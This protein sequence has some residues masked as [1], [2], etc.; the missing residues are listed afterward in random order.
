MIE[1]VLG[2]LAACA[3][4]FFSNPL[5]VV[6]TRL[7]LQGELRARN[8]Y[9]VRYR[10]VF[11]AFYAVAAADGILA[12]QKGLVP[13]LWYQL[14]MNGARLGTYQSFI[15][16]GFTKSSNG[17]ISVP[18]S[19]LCGATA[20]C[21]GAFIGSPFYLVKT[22]LQSQAAEQ[23]AVGHQH[24]HVGAT[25]A[26]VNIYKE[27]GIPGLWRGVTGAIPRV[28]V[29]SSTQLATFSKSKDFIENLDIFAKDSWLNA[30]LASMASAC[31]VITFMTPFDVVSTR[32]YN[33]GVDSG[34][35][36]LYYD[37]F[38][39]CFSKVLRTEGPTGFY[40]GW[41]A[42]LFRLGPHT[43]LS[44]VFWSKLRGVYLEWEASDRM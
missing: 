16:L 39:D 33:Q 7:Q 18:R 27:H 32:L 9:T 42:S 10:N 17:E 4:G 15:N 2:G 34:G 30:L 36:G 8:M 19:I 26:L 14:V 1:F 11:H 44:L 23:V 29:G 40:K 20:G 37:G 25:S 35:R 31:V 12:L 6:K 13:A 43:V 3:A 22:H 28:M 24:K 38:V 21:V 5:E 41:T